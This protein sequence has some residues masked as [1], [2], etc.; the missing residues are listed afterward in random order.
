MN[1]N[2][3][4]KLLNGENAELL[5]EEI[6]V[7][8]WQI[9]INADTNLSLEIDNYLNFYVQRLKEKYPKEIKRL[10]VKRLTGY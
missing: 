1:L 4:Y 5:D 6:G 9:H 8:G 3:Q 2:E 10:N 7:F